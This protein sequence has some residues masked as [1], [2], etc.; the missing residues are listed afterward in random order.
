MYIYI[1]L[2]TVTLCLPP[3]KILS[4]S[5]LMQK[6]FVGDLPATPLLLLNGTV[7]GEARHPWETDSP[8]AIKEQSDAKRWI[9]SSTSVKKVVFFLTKTPKKQLRCLSA[10]HPVQMAQRARQP[11]FAFKGSKF[12]SWRNFARLLETGWAA[13]FFICVRTWA[14]LGFDLCVCLD[15]S[16]S[17]TDN[18]FP[19]WLEMAA[20]RFIWAWTATSKTCCSSV[21]TNSCMHLTEGLKTCASHQ[22]A[23]EG[24]MKKARGPEFLLGFT[25]IQ[26]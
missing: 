18:A 17:C 23:P 13:S 9:L 24:A 15:L 2:L 21:C 12:P 1:T 25:P 7:Y 10:F 19:E 26:A 4:C 22:L 3:W 5:H 11:R 8:S 6:P 20:S 14:V 16:Q